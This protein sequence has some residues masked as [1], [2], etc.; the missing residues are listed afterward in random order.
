MPTNQEKVS[1]LLA[2]S[3]FTFINSQNS[4]ALHLANK[5]ISLA[6]KNANA[7]SGARN[8]GILMINSYIKSSGIF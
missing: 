2:D 3:H 7:Y 4:E 5:A 1:Q 6:P 8:F